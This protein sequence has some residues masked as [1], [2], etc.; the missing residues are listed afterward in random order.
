MIDVAQ[1]E[2]LAAQLQ[3]ADSASK[4]VDPS[5]PAKLA[6]EKLEVDTLFRHLRD[7]GDWKASSPLGLVEA[8]LWFLARKLS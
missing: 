6:I 2:R 1:I 4:S 5:L 7:D 3:A 8:G